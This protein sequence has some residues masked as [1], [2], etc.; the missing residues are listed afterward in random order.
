[1]S[2]KATTNYQNVLLNKVR[3]AKMP[4]A[5]F[6]TNGYVY[7]NCTV[8]G[9]DNYVVV[10]MC[11]SKEDNTPKQYMIYKHAI[12]TISPARPIDFNPNTNGDSN[13]TE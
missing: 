3:Q 12:S 5:I 10:I 8:V 2:G 11:K 9:F 13:A 6:L 1:M 7:S 4:C